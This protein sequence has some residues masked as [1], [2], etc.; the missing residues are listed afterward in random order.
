MEQAIQTPDC[1]FFVCITCHR[2]VYSFP[3][4]GREQFQ[5]ATC[6][7]LDINIPDP[8]EREELRARLEK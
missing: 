5:C 6:Q 8:V 1:D 7:W 4:T 2:D 3:F